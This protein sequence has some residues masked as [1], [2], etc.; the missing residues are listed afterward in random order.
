MLC[1]VCKKKLFGLRKW[2]A[3]SVSSSI[4][5]LP[6]S[7]RTWDNVFNV[8]GDAYNNQILV[9]NLIGKFLLF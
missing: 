6:P 9:L 7:I 8:L 1:Y 3:T 5:G 2:V 4:L